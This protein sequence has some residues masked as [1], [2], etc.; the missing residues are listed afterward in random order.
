MLDA[1]SQAPILVPG[2]SGVPSAYA[3]TAASSGRGLLASA[4]GSALWA[5][6]GANVHHYLGASP[7]TKTVIAATL[8]GSGICAMVD[9]GTHMVVVDLG[10]QDTRACTSAASTTVTPPAGVFRDVA[11]QDGYTIYARDGTDEFYISAL[12]DP[13]TI[14]ALDF[15]TADAQPG[16]IVA[17]RSVNRDLVILKN[18]STEFWV[19]T[20]AAAFPFE[21]TQPGVAST[22]CRGT[23]SVRH[24]DGVLYWVGHDGAAYAM[25]G[26][27]PVA[28]SRAENGGADVTSSLAESNAE[29]TYGCIALLGGQAVYMVREH[30]GSEPTF[31]YATQGGA[32]FAF[33][34]PLTFMA[35]FSA[36][37]AARA[38]TYGQM[39]SGGTHYIIANIDTGGTKVEAETGVNEYSLCLLRLPEIGSRALSTMHRLEVLFSEQDAATYDLWTADDGAFLSPR[40][41]GDGTVSTAA[42][43]W[44]RLGAFRRRSL[45]LYPGDG[46]LGASTENVTGRIIQIRAMIDESGE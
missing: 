20:G 2:L 10:G 23:H 18:T 28:I 26:Y 8:S 29:M 42:R 1:R 38:Q 44:A 34:P 40:N 17:I 13:T 31:A 22:G 33:Y 46:A 19:N 25:R 45:E 21:R 9:A 14:G 6:V 41:I 37:G 36:G 11:Y 4:D 30:G 43:R 15:S 24:H 16:D 3:K 39:T 32:W 12:D 27:Q 7:Y 5:V 35:I